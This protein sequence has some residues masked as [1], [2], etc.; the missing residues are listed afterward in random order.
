MGARRVNGKLSPVHLALLVKIRAEGYKTGYSG[1]TKR[2]DIYKDNFNNLIWV[3][4]YDVGEMHRL[5]GEPYGGKTGTN[6]WIGH[7]RKRLGY[8]S[9]GHSSSKRAGDD[10]PDEAHPG[11]NTKN[12]QDGTEAGRGTQSFG[13]QAR[14][15]S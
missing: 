14:Y 5:C 13:P 6:G 7:Q 8:C 9:V 1:G 3:N 12:V 10:S 15:G 11:H 4:A 2:I